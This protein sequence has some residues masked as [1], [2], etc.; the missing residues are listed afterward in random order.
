MHGFGQGEWSMAD[1]ARTESRMTTSQLAPT[2]ATLMRLRA[3]RFGLLSVGLLL[4][5]HGTPARADYQI[6]KEVQADNIPPIPLTLTDWGPST[7][8]LLGKDPFQV[9]LFDP[10]KHVDANGV[11]ATLRA[12]GFHLDA[13]FTNQ[14]SMEFRTPSTTTVKATGEMH[15]FGVGGRE[16]T[17]GPG[18]ATS[19]TVT[20]DSVP[21]NGTVNKTFA[22]TVYQNVQHNGFYR[23]SSPQVL[24]Q[25]TGSG[26]VSLPVYASAHSDFHNSS[27]NAVGISNTSAAASISV[28]YFYSF[29]PVPEPSSLALTGLGFVGLLAAG[30]GRLLRKDRAG[31]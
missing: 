26:T 28:V 2:G 3:G 16:L 29:V 11:K 21:K 20:V 24:A 15:L 1:Q 5:L 27:G 25:Y 30:R 18:F 6:F 14:V 17:V 9:Q 12:I 8:D 31:D 22:P 10:N 13:T 19:Q 4:A 23:E 7:P